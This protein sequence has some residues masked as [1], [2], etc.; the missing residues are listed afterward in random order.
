[1]PLYERSTKRTRRERR[2]IPLYLETLED[3]TV[4]SVSATL[5]GGMLVVDGEANA[6]NHIFLTLNSSTNQIVVSDGS[7]VTGSFNSAAVTDITVNANGF[8]NY[9]QIG[10]GVTQTATINGGPGNNYLIAGGGATTLV[11]GTGQ[12]RLVGGNGADTFIATHGDNTIEDGNGPSTATLSPRA[13]TV[14]TGILGNLHPQAGNPIVD[15]SGR[16]KVLG[17]KDRE[18]VTGL[19]PILDR[20]LRAAVTPPTFSS[21]LGIP[22]SPNSTISATQVG[23]LLNRAAAATSFDNAIVAIV[24]RNGDILGVRVE[25]GVSTA[26]T[27]NLNNLVFAIDGA[28]AE[29]RT[30]AFFAN[31]TAPL[32]SRTVQFI[33][34]STITQREVESNP[35]ITNPNS[36][37]A[38]PGVV[39]PIEIGGNFP[40]GIQNTA[41]VDLL[42]IEETNRDSTYK[43]I[44]DSAG[45]IIN[46]V[47]LP[48]RFNI[49]PAFIPAGQTL[50]PNPLNPTVN[51]QIIATPNSYGVIAGSGGVSFAT[52]SGVMYEGRGLGTLP[53]GIPIFDQGVLVGGIGVFFPGTTGFADEENSALS[54]NY[55]PN[56]ID[57]S[58]V[59]EYIAFA[60]VGGSSGAGFSIGSL[61]GVA[62]LQGFDL[63]F[64]QINLG[65]IQLPLFG[66]P[67]QDG[68]QQLVQFGQ[69][70]GT[71]NAASSAATPF[72]TTGTLNMPVN[73]DGTPLLNGMPAPEGWLVLPHAGTTLTANQV[74]Q[75]I[76][77]AVEQAEQTR[78]QIRLPLDNT[79]R[80]VIAVTDPE[81]GD[82]L[83]LFR[84][85]DS[86]IFSID[87]AVAKG[88]NN[89]YYDNANQLQSIDQLTGVSAGVA[90]SSRTY[91]Y[92]ASP[93]F[94]EGI[95]GSP[96]GPFSILNVP[97]TNTTTGLNTGAPVPASAYFNNIVGHNNFFPTTNFHDP[98]NLLNQNGVV[99][100][101]GGVPLYADTKLAGGLGVSGDGVDEDDVVTAGGAV[102]FGPPNTVLTVDDFL[103]NGVRL[104]YQLFDRNP[105]NL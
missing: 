101:P 42:N 14:S 13:T 98:F 79:T 54:S 46:F 53:G 71:G 18:T 89:A 100:F 30:G 77:Q 93:F 57:L 38:G 26:I 3:R 6:L 82:V 80:M 50:L 39:G 55:N 86:T 92:L 72:N 27:G 17:Y 37:V 88:R 104:P 99:F 94:P 61:G 25:G 24:D 87:V 52:Q 59:A 47:P 68:T 103:F 2:S 58:E 44:Y 64:G 16:D 10:D 91:R 67:G 105:T 63:P 15:R 9:V 76:V 51:N 69:T 23:T 75:I 56:K 97:G 7:H 34:Q 73:I 5:S 62:P 43:P 81:T 41:L 28:V 32:T 65:G 60:A 33:S 95:N 90:F 22:P 1:M 35:S 29:A 74:D 36:T 45:N 40:P 20:D 8:S 48:Q 78:A 66:P 102:G 19:D 4:M 11:S 84:M 96:P 49:N 21:T 12:N 83:G 70:L 31:D 85:P